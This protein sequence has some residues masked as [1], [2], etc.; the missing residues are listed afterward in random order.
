MNILIHYDQA[1]Q[2]ADA[3]G[4]PHFAAGIRA[5]LVREIERSDTK[6][7][8]EWVLGLPHSLAPEFPE[9]RY[10]QTIGRGMRCT[11]GNDVLYGFNCAGKARP[12][13][14]VPSVRDAL[15]KLS[16]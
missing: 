6:Q 1:A 7:F 11:C 15:D 14:C 4:C 9:H 8:M 2:R 13:V 5:L 16:Q 3:D 10:I 12:H